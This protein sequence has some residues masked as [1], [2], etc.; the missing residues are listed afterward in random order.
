MTTKRKL[1]VGDPVNAY[2]SRMERFFTSAL[3][4]LPSDGQFYSGE[5]TEVL[6]LITRMQPDGSHIVCFDGKHFRITQTITKLSILP[7]Y[8]PDETRVDIEEVGACDHHA[9]SE[10]VV[11]SVNY[12]WNNLRWVLRAI[13][14]LKQVPEGIV[15]YELA[16]QE[17]GRL[18]GTFVSRHNAGDYVLPRLIDEMEHL[19]PGGIIRTTETT[20]YRYARGVESHYAYENVKGVL[21]KYQTGGG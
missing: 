18:T 3:H 19:P 1:D 10:G 11:F 15:L 14:A 16:Y 5:E 17:T 4:R 8:F 2:M 9:C 7:Q 13:G 21:E 6:V 20:W 12:L